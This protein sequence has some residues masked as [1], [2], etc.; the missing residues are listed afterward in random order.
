M[1]A[2]FTGVV[3]GTVCWLVSL[4]GLL[5]GGCLSDAVVVEQGQPRAVIVTADAPVPSARDAAD[6]LQ[7]TISQM[8]GATLPIRTESEFNGR[9]VP[10]LVGQSSLTAKAGVVV[11]QDYGAG[12]H[13]VIRAQG[14]RVI[15][16]GNDAGRLR[17]TAYAAYDLLQRLGCGW[18]G[19]DP[20]WQVIPRTQ[21]LAVPAMQIEERPAFLL[22]DNWVVQRL[23]PPLADAWRTGGWR[24]DHGHAFE[25]WLPRK[26]YEAEH[27]DWFGKGQPCLTHPQVI[28]TVTR[29]LRE[30]LD[31]E[32][33]EKG[34]VSFSLSAN[35]NDEFCEC[36]RCKAAGNVSA[37]YLA[38]V[39]TIAR[40]LATTHPNRYL[41]TF[42]AYWTVHEPP[43][44]ML[45]AEL[46]VCVMQVNEGNHM[47]PWDWPESE[48]I[49]KLD[50]NDN[51]YRE[52]VAFEGWQKT[53]AI[54]GIYEWWIP[55]ANRPVWGMVPWYSG[56]TALR[57]LR[58]W[59]KGGVRYLTYQTGMEEGNGFPLR[60][61]LYYVGA[62][63]M[64]DPSLTSRQIMAEACDKLYGS[65]SRPMQRYYE[66]VERA[67]LD[68]PETLRGF[69][70]KLPG[71][72]DIYPPE[73][74]AAAAAALEEAGRV[75][76]EPAVTA[77][78]DQE[79]AIWDRARQAI[80][81]AR[82][83][84]AEEKKSATQPN[85]KYN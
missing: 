65:A 53:G 48:R 24:L 61:P 20:A 22:R 76:V 71:P 4:C 73:I 59:A 70:W 42:Y 52:V 77:R 25:R 72:E 7:K 12:D 82:Q 69:A 39:N 44:P 62:R 55:R 57:N 81:K 6:A 33:G 79:L 58:Y 36:D 51:N 11:E 45:R 21:T 50:R 29:R 8:T 26:Q 34:L 84:A 64:W 63:G 60:W 16:V 54:L 17:G 35:D 10:I 2:R 66:I 13:Y 40:N 3:L 1:Q 37:R 83:A 19:P 32:G 47:K 23:G 75:A 28:E 30:R 46:G 67:M 27:P 15:L 14:R 78:I 80:A 9:A 41:L 5:A 43:E 38:F 56:E 85:R 31:L 49:R 18:Y 68:A 74:E